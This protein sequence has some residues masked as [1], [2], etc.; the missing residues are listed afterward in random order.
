MVFSF[1]PK[2]EQMDSIDYDFG[3]S[4]IYD[5][6]CRK[7]E[8][9]VASDHGV[10]V[11]IDGKYSSTIRKSKQ[12][13]DGL[14]TNFISSI[15]IDQQGI[16]WLGT[17][18]K[19]ICVYRPKNEQFKFLG[20]ETFG[21]NTLVRSMVQ[22]KYNR[23]FVCT[24]EEVEVLAMKSPSLCKSQFASMG[25]DSKRSLS[26]KALKVGTPSKV[27]LG[28][29]GDI[30]V[31]TSEGNILVYDK[32]LG[33]KLSIALRGGPKSVNTVSDIIL[34]GD[35]D[36]WIS[37]YAGIF[38]L[39]ENSRAISPFKPHEKGLHTNYF[40]S[41]FE[42][43]SGDFWFG[44]NTG[45]Y[46]YERAIDSFE[47]YKYQSNDMAQSPAFNFVGGFADLGD[48]YLW[49][50]TYG[51]GLS[52]L[53]IGSKTFEHF[54]IQNGLANAVL[55]ALATDEN[56]DFWLS[57]NKGISHFDR[58]SERFINY[59]KED[60][61]YFNEFVLNSLTKNS[62]GELFFGT[63]SGIVVFNPSH[64]THT[65]SS[66]PVYIEEVEINYQSET[67]LLQRSGIRLS[68]KDKALTLHFS[69]LHFNRSP[70]IRYRFKLDGYDQD[71]IETDERSTTYTSL[72][73]GEFSFLLSTSNSEGR[74]TEDFLKLDLTVSP[75]FYQTWWFRLT[76][77]VVFFA[78]TIIIIVYMSQRKMRLRFEQLRTKQEIQQEKQRISRDL[79]DNIG[80][81]ITYLIS[82]IEHESL[83]KKE[84]STFFTAISE[85]ARNVMVQL[86]NTIWVLDRESI[87]LDD[88]IE[89]IYDYSNKVFSP[90]AISHEVISTNIT[91]QNL[92][93]VLVT[94]L[95][96]I[97]QETFTNIIKHSEAT[98]VEINFSTQN[99]MI[100][101]DVTDNGV[102][103]DKIK[104]ES[105][106]KFGIR[107]MRDRAKEMGG[108]FTIY[109]SENGVKTSIA[110]PA[111]GQVK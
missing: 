107:N 79:H 86:R 58:K 92:S 5:L 37:T 14:P 70:R 67:G 62:V 56:G 75:P 99:D 29:D 53:N 33:L 3:E 110:V 82:S 64:I 52:K 23:L 109:N 17:T 71:W 11:F 90:T 104:M 76:S 106:G 68:P 83:N 1:N 100:H 10:I 111:Q 91:M 101:I 28:H 7:N 38:V 105:L 2:N 16:I 47:W 9:W 24:D 22:D 60:G 49:M 61:L 94:N 102:G 21:E 98:E 55:N 43:I 45:I 19:G 59:W 27:A 44:T 26:V 13:E 72:P 80:A 108:S 97:L 30:L 96:R 12:F 41:V 8:L 95:F 65:K 51:G 93:P 84:E 66:V 81:Q 88:F 46:K 87:G 31:G 50:A 40:L 34:S 73:P 63:P 4:I 36:F 35:G 39:D 25:I 32:E 69:G 48:G 20:K 77:F 54:S 42:D 74:W 103:L 89:K 15:S 6:A 85:K 78:L 18:S 57:T